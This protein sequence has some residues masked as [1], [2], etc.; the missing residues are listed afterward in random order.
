MIIMAKKTKSWTNPK[1]VSFNVST[2]A[3]TAFQRALF[4]S[5]NSKIEGIGI[6]RWLDLELPVDRDRKARGHCIDLIGRAEDNSMVICELKF[7]KPG[8]GSP[9]KA[10]E[11]LENYYKAVIS[12]YDK[13]DEG[14]TLHHKNTLS[15]GHFFWEEIAS[16][17][18]KLI[19]AAND[20]YWI[21]WEKKGELLPFR[22]NCYKINIPTNY[23]KM[24][25][26]QSK[27]EKYCPKVPLLEW[28]LVK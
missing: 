22:T 27:M 12:N 16:D 21:F 3:E 6:V 18:T 19:I 17:S 9:Q 24:L 28:R 15:H 7:G 11:Q 25:K 13:L 4:L 2:T 8:N 1:D 14:N 5:E 20:D 10:K 26:E 23:F